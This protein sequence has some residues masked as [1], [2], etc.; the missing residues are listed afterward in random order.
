MWV[1]YTKKDYNNLE[2]Y[3]DAS[4]LGSRSFI[5][6]KMIIQYVKLLNYVLINH[7]SETGIVE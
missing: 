7:L 1:K 3:L 4:F 6:I 5:N 2:I